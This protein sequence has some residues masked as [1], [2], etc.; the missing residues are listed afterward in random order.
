MKSAVRAKTLDG[1][2]VGQQNWWRRC[3]SRRRYA[4]LF[5]RWRRRFVV[6][7]D[8]AFCFRHRGDR[9]VQVN[10]LQLAQSIVD[11]WQVVELHAEL[12]KP[13][14]VDGTV[15]ATCCRCRRNQ[16]MPTKVT[17][18]PSSP[19][20]PAP[21][22]FFRS[23]GFRISVAC[24]LGLTALLTAALSTSLE[25]SGHFQTQT[26]AELRGP[27]RRTHP[28]V[29]AGVF[30]SV[31]LSNSTLLIMTNCLVVSRSRTKRRRF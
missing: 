17:R 29:Q 1:I 7:E 19:R 26:H 22:S 16:R 21:I 11:R 9:I 18:S 20:T 30:V 31:D 27:P 3:R 23:F 15:C 28:P 2:D 5:Y 24:I 14:G 12:A 6:D 10:R 4:E 8:V 13:T 25:I